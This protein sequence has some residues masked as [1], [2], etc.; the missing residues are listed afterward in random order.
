M[1]PNINDLI[2]P[3]SSANSLGPI[4][5]PMSA[6]PQA[7]N[8]GSGPLTAQP[9]QQ[10]AT[11]E[12]VTELK[13]LLE[14]VQGQNGKLV[15][16]NLSGRNDASL[17]KQDLFGK[18]FEIMKS[19]GVDPAN[20]ESIRS[21]LELLAK[22]EPDLLSI[23]ETAFGGLMQD[24]GSAPAVPPDQPDA[25]AAPAASTPAPAGPDLMAQN[26]SMQAMGPQQ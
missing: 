15:A 18:L 1:Q 24:P 17:M 11:P 2:G 16:S 25:S 23:F 13:T 3:Q 22:T 21:F 10:P 14:Q 26:R 9:G 5:P 4:K 6:V 12:Q 20:P 8:P 19:A 7:I